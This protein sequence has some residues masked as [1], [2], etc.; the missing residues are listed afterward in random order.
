[1]NNL[2]SVL[3]ISLLFL[4]GLYRGAVA[5]PVVATSAFDS[6]RVYPNPWKADQ[7]SNLL[8]TFDHMAL[9]TTVKIFTLSGRLV[10]TLDADNG[11]TTWD[12]K[13]DSGDAVASGVYLYLL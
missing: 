3:G 5:V 6:M 12:R 11:S 4:A 2:K 10:R 9:H 8:I 13:N 7:H 1:M